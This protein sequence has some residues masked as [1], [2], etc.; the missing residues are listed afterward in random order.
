MVTVAV[1]LGFISLAVVPLL[2]KVKYCLN[3]HPPEQRAVLLASGTPTRDFPRTSSNPYQVAGHPN[4]GSADTS[5]SYR[6][7]EVTRRPPP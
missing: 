4:Y 7:P 1:V 6:P 5:A 3:G 2:R